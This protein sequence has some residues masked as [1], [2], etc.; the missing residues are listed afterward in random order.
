MS[1]TS[2]NTIN[3]DLPQIKKIRSQ[4]LRWYRKHARILSWRGTKDPYKVWLCEIILQQT[5]IEQGTAYYFQFLEKFPTLKHLAL[6]NETQVLKVWEGL[7]YY[8]RA[9]N[10]LKAA[11][12]IYHQLKGKFPCKYEELIKLPGIGSYTASAIGSICFNLPTPTI[13]GNVR[14]VLSRLFEISGN[15][16]SGPFEKTTQTIAEHLISHKYPADFN[17][18]MMD[19][20]STIC[21][22]ANPSCPS[23]PL[24]NYCLAYQHGTQTDFPPKKSFRAIPV[25]HW[26]VAVVENKNKV[27]LTWEENRNFLKSLYALPSIEIAPGMDTAQ[28]QQVLTQGLQLSRIA[29][30]FTWKFLFQSVRK[31]SHRTINFYVYKTILKPS[32][33]II[34]PKPYRWVLIKEI[35]HYPFSRAYSEIT[36][37]IFG[38]EY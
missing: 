25:L 38:N 5:R 30:N 11:Q 16:N 28:V 34:V 19:I 1:A 3:L 37:R 15:I 9:R 6:A 33:R 23:C 31:Y 36:E 12:I 8:T 20:G 10:L 13:D 26:A 18:G 29:D 35:H 17:Q 24:K 32:K 27:L 7:G 22:P 4:V 14:R 2:N 21:V